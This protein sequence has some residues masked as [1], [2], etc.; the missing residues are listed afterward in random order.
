MRSKYL[1]FGFVVA[2]LYTAA[3]VLGFEMGGT[4]TRGPR[5]VQGLGGY[6]G[7]K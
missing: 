1:L 3:S 5:G 4:V 2:A 6:R 7:G